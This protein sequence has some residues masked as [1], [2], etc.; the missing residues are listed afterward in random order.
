MC[1]RTLR[2]DG[3]TTAAYFFR[4]TP[5]RSGLVLAPGKLGK[6]GCDVATETFQR[7]PW[8]Q[9]PT[10]KGGDHRPEASLAWSVR[11]GGCEA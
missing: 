11:E 1:E 8:V 9:V 6:G 5:P 4:I 7:D 10:G 3:S 2:E